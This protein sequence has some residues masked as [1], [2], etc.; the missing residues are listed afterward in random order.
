MNRLLF[1]NRRLL[2][3]AIALV[4]VAGMS[5]LLVLPRME[6]PV[7][8][9]RAA[10]INARL[11]GAT[12]ERVEA[13]VV[14]PLEEELREIPEIKEIRTTARSGVAN[15]VVE[16]R[17]DVYAASEV[18]SRVRNKIDDAGPQLPPE[19]SEPEFDLLE[20]TAYASIVALRWDA[21]T[22]VNYAVLRR[23][24]EEL[25]RRL[26]AVGGTREVDT[27]GDPAEEITI[28]IDP[29]RLATLGLSVADVARQLAASDAKIAAGQLRAADGSLVIEVDSE[30]DTVRRIASTPIRIGADDDAGRLVSLGAVADV[31][32][33]VIDPPTRL[34]L[35]DGKPAI[36]VAVLV[37]GDQRID[38]WAAKADKVVKAFGAELPPA[39]GMK[40]VF[41]QSGYVET[42]LGTLLWNLVAGAAAVM[43]VVWLMM[44]WRSAVV[45]GSALPLASLMVLAGMRWMGIPIHQMSVTGLI[46]ALGLLI[47]NAIVIVD[48]VAER[49]HGGESPGEA[50]ASAVSHLA[51]PLFGS[52]LTTCLSFA[53]IALMPGPAGE[54]VGAIAVSVMM[55]VT[56]SFFL[57]MTVTPAIAAI[58]LPQEQR[59]ERPWWSSGLRSDRLTAGYSTLLGFLFRHPLLG[60]SLPVAAPVLG[61][62][63]AGSLT[64]QF[65]PPAERDQLQ[66]QMDLPAGASIDAT[67]RIADD[68]R[69]LLLQNPRVKAVDWFLGESGPAFYYNMIANRSGVPQYAQA[70]VQIDSNED[71]FG[72][73]REVQQALNEALP[74]AR[75]LV[76]QL[77]QGPP[78]DAPIEARLF[79]P[80]LDELGRLG[81]EVRRVMSQTADIVH[82]QSDLSETLPKLAVTV[83][84]ASAR[85]AGL[86][87]ETVAR[88]LD[89]TLEGA[90]G[91]S[92]LEGTESLPVRVRV[93]GAERSDLNHIA[94]TDLIGRTATGE[95]TRTPL[96]AVA[97]LR[98]T[99]ERSAI[100]HF[101]SER[102]N[103]VKAFITAGAL[104]SEVQGRFVERLAG[105]GF[106]LP[107]GYRLEYGGE[108]SKRN[109]AVGNLM[110]NVAVL[111]VLMAATLVLSFGSFRMAA[112]IGAVAAL[113]VG[114]ALGS[115]AIAGYPFGF[116][117]IIG[118]MGLIGVGINDTIVVLAA[119]RDDAKAR[120]GD[121][122]AIRDVVVRSSR[123]VIATTLTTIAG[124]MPLILGGGGFWP[125][126]AITIA[127]GVGGATLLALVLAPSAYTLL[128]CPRCEE[129]AEN[130]AEITTA[131][132]ATLAPA[133]G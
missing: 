59:G 65:F 83:D 55:A 118:T 117:A 105:S 21:P 113:S 36:A 60:I 115:L 101:N 62:V 49:M 19:A 52:T 7:L 91:G 129:S 110:S 132:E 42:R 87:N 1:D 79:G 92:V 2:M 109:D 51:G 28:E 37:R 122:A 22:D 77:E 100:P 72:V 3:L 69:D 64:E 86:D 119:I 108:G 127:G 80:D 99:P 12:P 84:E 85:L 114:L 25:D 93:A 17:D 98:L 6:D 112:I 45:V 53:P 70:M 90:V 73:V 111:L 95:A 89:A 94:A 102:M 107:P 106:T 75:F 128:M 15:I 81:R 33:G 130:A 58:F 57:A 133:T 78:F 35:V 116:T 14:E 121:A 56:S 4:V 43:V 103:E 131:T 38:V 46:I 23:L 39:V 54:F 30:L 47:D 24:A 71:Y 44:G 40:R 96:S 20:V 13:L 120:T 27:F 29:A 5:S 10:I 82:T 8:T 104:P 123:H 48:E 76:R 126:M 67:R 9:Q 31:Q 66:I 34:A 68:A 26:L 125:P 41:E 50:V 16:L 18:W 124:F 63:L 11:P 74:A 32:K 61:F 88:Q 97:D